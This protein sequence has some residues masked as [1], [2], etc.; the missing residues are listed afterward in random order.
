MEFRL[1][2]SK[3]MDLPPER[4]PV[5]GDDEGSSTPVGARGGA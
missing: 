1:A 4:Q 5:P 2:A 3:P